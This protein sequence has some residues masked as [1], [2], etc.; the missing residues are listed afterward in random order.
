MS[1]GCPALC[2]YRGLPRGTPRRLG[3]LK[4]RSQLPSATC[5]WGPAPPLRRAHLGALS[6]SFPGLLPAPRDPALLGGGGRLAGTQGFGREA[7][8]SGHWGRRPGTRALGQ[9]PGRPP[10][11]RLVQEQLPTPLQEG[12]GWSF[13]WESD[14]GLLRLGISQPTHRHTRQTDKQRNPKKDSPSPYS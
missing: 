11:P 5:R 2:E 9:T 12:E 3:C 8:R 13:F 6:R 4:A 14:S 1:A 7:G 10:E